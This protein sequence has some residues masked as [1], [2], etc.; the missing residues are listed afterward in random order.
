MAY[1]GEIEII[2]NW[3]DIANNISNVTA[4]FYAV[5]DN[6]SAW[7]N[8]ATYAGL[9]LD[10][11]YIDSC[12]DSYNFGKNKR[13]LLGSLTKNVEHNT[14][15]TKT[16]YASFSWTAGNSYIGTVTGSNSLILTNIPRYASF[17]EHYILDTD[18]TSI[19]VHWNADS[20]CDAVEYSIDGGNWQLTSGLTYTITG[21]NPNTQYSIRTAIK[22][23]DSQLWTESGYL[24]AT[25]KDIAKINNVS[26][27]EHGNNTNVQITNPARDI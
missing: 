6:G 21:L 18:L 25:T 2:Q 8:D 19:T 13:L 12:V 5:S 9:T 3:Q 27:F 16:V 26:D 1:W 22:R 15:G 24:Y 14:D 10:G 23:R 11:T 4:N 20:S 17:A 7:K